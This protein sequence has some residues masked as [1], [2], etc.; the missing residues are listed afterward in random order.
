M[1]GVCATPSGDGGDKQ[2]FRGRALPWLAGMCKSKI[3]ILPSSFDFHV[4]SEKPWGRC[5]RQAK[6]WDAGVS[7]VWGG[8]GRVKLSQIK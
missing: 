6:A 7:G 4:P 2:S 1:V 3:P 8:R 5:W